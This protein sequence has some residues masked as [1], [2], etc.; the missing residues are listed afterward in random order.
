MARART[1]VA[2]VAGLAALALPASALAGP[3]PTYAGSVSNSTNL[4]SIVSLAVS[5]NYAYTT[6]YHPGQ[7]TVVDISNPTNP[8]VVGATPSNSNLI[9]GSNIAVVGNYAYVVSKNRNASTSSNDDGNGNSL[10]IVDISN[11]AAPTV[12]GAVRDPNRLF[13]SYGVAVQGNYAYVAYQGVLSG[14]P[15]V[16]DTS[17]GGFTVVDISNPASPSIVGN[18]DNSQLKGSFFN[19]LY[20]ATSVAISGH[21]AYVNAFYANRITV[22]DISNPASPQVKAVV[23]D[24][25]HLGLVVDLA[26]QG[27]YLYAADQASGTAPQL[28]IFDISTPTN[29]VYVGSLSNGAI[30]NNAYRIRVSGNFAYESAK[31]SSA[32]AAID[33]SDPRNPRMAGWFQ[34]SKYLY[35][36]TGLD[37]TGDLRHVVASSFELSG[38]SNSTY[39][40]YPGQS[41][42]A[43]LTGTVSVTSL[44]PNPIGVGITADPPVDTTATTA[45]FSFSPTDAVA[46]LQCSLDGAPYGPCTSVAQNNTSAG[47]QNYA[48]LAVGSHTFSVQATDAAGNT[49]STGY[50]W[51]VDTVPSNTAPP[52]ISGTAAP[53]QTLAADPGTW[54]GS[55]APSY[56][57]Q[58]DL[59]DASGGSCSPIN[60][61]TGQTYTVQPGDA[62][63]TVAVSVTGTNPVG[64]SS[65]TSQPAAVA[66]TAQV[67]ANTSPPSISGTA[68]VGSVLTASPGNWS[69]AATSSAYQWQRCNPTCGP[70]SGATASIYT[71]TSSDAGATIEVTVTASNGAGSGQPATSGPTATVTEAP[72]S[73]GAPVLSGTAGQGQ[74]LSATTGSWNAYPP[75][76]YSYQWQRCASSCANISGATAATYVLARAD[77]GTSVKVL[78]S[79]A[80]GVGN[81]G[82]AGSQTTA[83]VTGP[84][85]DVSAP[86]ISGTATQGSTLT[87][88]AGRWT[89]YPAPSFTYKWMRCNSSGELCSAI[90]GATATS[91]TLA[92]AD[93]GATLRTYVYGTNSVGTAL[94]RSA[95][96]AI[97]QAGATAAASIRG[98]RAGRPEMR[99]V[100]RAARGA[101]GL[102]RVVVSL[103]RGFGFAS[104]SRVLRA[105]RVL[106]PHG[107]RLRVTISVHGRT[108]TISTRSR[109]RVVTIVVGSRGLAIAHGARRSGR[110]RAGARVKLVIAVQQAG[111]AVIHQL[112]YVRPS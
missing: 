98:V 48:G 35:Q 67:P 39:P 65:A 8:I 55:P 36:T 82:T 111:R 7:L 45:G 17:K 108:L 80:N 71:L 73:T 21:Y 15:Q 26:I 6:A 66:G 31:N 94:G 79:A 76:S 47:T 43:P 109:P 9:G 104:R 19:G 4:S 88:T 59:C 106:D 22:I 28:A 112:L 77:V 37:L 81:P 16:P 13:G 78:V 83:T 62:G 23:A 101:P 54:S 103:P 85:L 49:A 50:T 24:G 53:G 11:P 44:D 41:G 70:I 57:Y 97:V 40:P 18:I 5:G 91:Y 100:A 52:T 33:V 63:L 72:Q 46:S 75:P 61:A 110:P 92:A 12:V 69:P 25:N 107:R 74:T 86:T 1:I 32:V 93:V 99:I 2:L 60:G 51:S 64:F 89:G 42:V 56:G 87:T 84:P 102:Q 68:S 96:T 27:N 95:A 29:P 58:W 34:S 105:V 10:T 3:A 20:H 90:S 14:Q 30:L 38:Q